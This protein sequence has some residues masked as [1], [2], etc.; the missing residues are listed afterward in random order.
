MCSNTDTNI[1]L[2]NSKYM[3]MEAVDKNNLH[4]MSPLYHI[5]VSLI[6]ASVHNCIPV[7]AC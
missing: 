7:M 4:N 3:L 5:L 1:Q 6:V 2:H